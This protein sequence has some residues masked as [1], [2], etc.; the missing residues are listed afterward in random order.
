MACAGGDMVMA[1]IVSGS[2]GRPGQSRSEEVDM[3]MMM[4][5]VGDGWCR[6][7]R[8]RCSCQGTMRRPGNH[9]QIPP[10]CIR[11]QFAVQTSIFRYTVSVGQ[12]VRQI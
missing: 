9:Q 1:R 11:S 12:R 2:C 7:A 3:V 4:L 5:R 6:E 10:S 8:L